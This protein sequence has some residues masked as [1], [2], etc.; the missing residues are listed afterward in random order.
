[1]NVSKVSQ[2]GNIAQ[3]Y[4]TRRIGAHSTSIG[5]NGRYPDSC[6]SPPPPDLDCDDDVTYRNFRVQQPDPHRFDSERDGL[7]CES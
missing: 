3:E 4:I 1:M 2:T 6:I 5:R 7:G